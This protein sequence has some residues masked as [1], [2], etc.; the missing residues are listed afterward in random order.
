[1]KSRSQ[2]G[3]RRGVH[4][5][6]MVEFALSVG[7]LMPAL[8]GVFQFGYAFYTYNRLIVAVRGGARYAALRT[9]DSATATP[10]SAYLTA[11]QN[12]TLYGNPAGGTNPIV[13]GVSAD[14]IAVAVTMSNSAPDMITVSLSSFTVDTV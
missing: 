7:L 8:L 10:S 3:R 1:M 11:V 12:M 4:G 5:N 2:K 13:S 14:H 9:Y 6:A